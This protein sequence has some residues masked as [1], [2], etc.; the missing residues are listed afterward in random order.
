MN[1]ADQIEYW[2]GPA[3]QKWVDQ[4]NR[5]DAMLAP[6]ADKV[7]AAADLKS[8]EAVMDIGCGAGALN[9]RAAAKVGAAHG[10]LGVDVSAPLIALARARAAEANAPA[11]FELADASV[12][13]A[14]DP[15]GIVISRFGVMFFE[16]PAPA[17]ANIR[18]S[19]KPDGRL[20]F[21]CWQA[22]SLND[23]ALAPLQ[24]AM[25]FLKEAPAPA[26][27]T[28]PGPFAF[29]DKDRVARI[30]S[31]AGWA[32][33]SIDP[34]ETAIILPGDD[35]ETT[36]KFM[37]QLGPLS[38]LLAAQGIDEAQVEA[39]L[40]TLM[41]DHKKPDGRIAMKSACWMVSADNA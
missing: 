1:N 14:P 33:V 11:R 36:A 22:L 6:F 41:Q 7:I 24:A 25:A 20:A 29:H 13:T 9:L 10:A 19:V 8:G 30:L 31:D 23:W 21:I 16:D 17:F 12:F 3:G 38:R 26:D 34:V 37:M 39:A 32:N 40:I 28:A 5:L 27:P 18:Q 15:V 2:N 35:V 4:S